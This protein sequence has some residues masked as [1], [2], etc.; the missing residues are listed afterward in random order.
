MEWDSNDGCRPVT[1]TCIVQAL[2]LQHNVCGNRS[3]GSS[4]QNMGRPVLLHESF[5]QLLL[6]PGGF[7]GIWSSSVGP[8]KMKSNPAPFLFNTQATE[9][10]IQVLIWLPSVAGRG[11]NNGHVGDSHDSISLGSEDP[12]TNFLLWSLKLLIFFIRSTF[13]DTK[14]SEE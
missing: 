10:E 2:G 6:L 3:R 14:T 1:I 13:Q 5:I 8:F 12:Y 11:L 4:W 7:Q 9:Y